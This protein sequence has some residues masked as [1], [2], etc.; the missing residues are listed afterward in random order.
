MKKKKKKKKKASEQEDTQ[1]D[2]P[3]DAKIFTRRQNYSVQIDLGEID[4]DL[5]NLG[6]M[7]LSVRFTSLLFFPSLV[8]TE[9]HGC[10]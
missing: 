1:I 9:L 4:V 2:I 8:S 7:I 10:C 5:N 6:S 3:F